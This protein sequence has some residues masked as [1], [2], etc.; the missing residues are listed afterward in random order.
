MKEERGNVERETDRQAERGHLKER[1]EVK[2]GE[3][4]GN[5]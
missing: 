4:R 3:G 1:S 5:L 2:K